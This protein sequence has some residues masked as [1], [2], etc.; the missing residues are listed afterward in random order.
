[1]KNLHDYRIRFLDAGGACIDETSVVAE[2]L[3]IATDYGGTIG[4]EMGAADFFV[5][6]VSDVQVEKDTNQISKILD[7]VRTACFTAIRS[8]KTSSLAPS[9]AAK[10]G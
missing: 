8:I 3:S 6:S 10:Q 9:S 5:T 7:R 2:S 1:M 4:D